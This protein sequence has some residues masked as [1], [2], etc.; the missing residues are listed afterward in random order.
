MR[1][2]HKAWHQ[3]PFL[4]VGYRTV[5]FAKGIVSVTGEK[6]GVNGQGIDE[7]DGG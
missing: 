1:D 7:P 4:S 6:M 3:S 2:K 5:F